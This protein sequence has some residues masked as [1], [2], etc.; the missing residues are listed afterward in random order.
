MNDELIAALSV[1]ELL[2]LVKELLAEIEL[3]LMQKEGEYHEN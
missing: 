2:D 3:R 1:P